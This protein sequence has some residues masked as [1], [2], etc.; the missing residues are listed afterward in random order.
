MPVA[1]AI[2]S[3]LQEDVRHL[4]AAAHA[5]SSALYP[6]ESNHYLGVEALA[7]GDVTFLV[8]RAGTH[9]IGTGALRRHDA[10]LGEIKQ[11]WI[12]PDMRGRQLGR[13]M[14]EAIEARGRALGLHRLAL[15]TGI[16]NTEALGLYRKSGYRECL[17][18]ADYRPDPLSVFLSKTL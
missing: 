1:I 12:D 8:A 18:F 6:A 7:A 14:L 3:P 11:M 10:T 15:E 5:V 4:I 17:P 9:A 2:E 13:R 16:R